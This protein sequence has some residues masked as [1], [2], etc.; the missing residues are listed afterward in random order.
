MSKSLDTPTGGG[1]KP[2]ISIANKAFYGLQ[3]LTTIEIPESTKIIAGGAF[4]DCG[5]LET[6]TM[7][8]TSTLK[9]IGSNA[10]ENC[11]ALKNIYLLDGMIE[12]GA[13]AF[14]NCVNLEVSQIPAS[15]TKIGAYAFYN[16]PKLITELTIPTAITE[17]EAGTFYNC[18]SLEKIVIHDKVTKIKENAFYSCCFDYVILPTSVICVEDEAFSY[19]TGNIL[20]CGTK[21]QLESIELPYIPSSSNPKSILGENVYVYYYSE[22]EPAEFG[23]YWYYN[24]DGT[25]KYW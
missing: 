12:I 2:V 11:R 5:K 23:R 4:Y 20:Y 22:T 10:F 1:G 25:I 21:E 19:T 8:S 14:R 15:I 9:S 13:S 7:Y 3:W 18:C 24:N 17:I 16:C 6:I